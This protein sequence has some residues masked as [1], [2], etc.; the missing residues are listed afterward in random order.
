M[1]END[2]FKDDVIEYNDEQAK[3]KTSNSVLNDEVNT[4]D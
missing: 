4:N 3:Q 1:I 2:S